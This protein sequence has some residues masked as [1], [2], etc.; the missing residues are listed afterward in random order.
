MGWQVLVSL[1]D[2]QHAQ[3]ILL[4]LSFEPGG[5]SVSDACVVNFCR[6]SWMYPT[7]VELSG[8]GRGG[9][10][11]TRTGCYKSSSTRSTGGMRRRS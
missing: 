5:A 8:R 2:L 10:G 1:Y 11:G 6:M 4:I 9:G 3:H 7:R